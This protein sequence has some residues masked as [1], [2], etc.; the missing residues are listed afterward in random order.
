[1]TFY[2][3]AT[4]LI[5]TTV[6]PLAGPVGGPKTASVT[7][8]NTNSNLLTVGTHA[9]T[10]FYGGDSNYASITSAVLNQTVAPTT[11]STGGEPTGTSVTVTFTGGGPVYGQPV[12]LTARVTAAYNGKPSGTVSFTDAGTGIPGAVATLVPCTTPATTC[13]WSTATIT[14]PSGSLP[15]LST[16]LRPSGLTTL[17]AHTIGAVYSGDGN[18]GAS[19]AAPPV[20]QNITA[21]D[22]TTTVTTLTTATATFGQSPVILAAQ[23]LPVA[24]GAGTRVGTISFYDRVSGIK[25]LA[26]NHGRG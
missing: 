13:N 5:G 12:T 3:G 11:S 21:A 20:S 23:V 10:A 16:T 25:L 17:P 19:S 8:S 9:I 26:G 18:F 14:L 1:V 15:G 2:D 7:V 4:Q 24:P 6:Q 22:T